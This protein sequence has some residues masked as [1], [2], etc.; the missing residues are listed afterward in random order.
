MARN[1]LLCARFKAVFADSSR[2]PSRENCMSIRLAVSY[3]AAGA[4]AA[5]LVVAASGE[6]QAQA[7]VLR[8]CGAKYQA[9]KAANE[10]GGKSWQDFLK[11]CRASLAEQPKTEAP[12][13][14]P[15]K[16]EAPKVESAKPEPA[17]PE[18]A[19]SEPVKTEP[20]K[21]E[22]PKAEAPAAPAPAAETPKPAAKTTTAQRQ[23]Q[24]AAEWK[25][26][27]AELVKNDPKLKWPKFWSACN[28]R[29]KEGGQ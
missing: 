10:L 2:L 3:A 7:N 8:E 29:L 26:Q 4:F 19:K 14:E 24:C 16:Q 20:A 1:L 27:K 9:A 21:T 22:P 15:A 5:C 17:K 18:P 11:E 6:A 12:A 25:A 28:K 13:A 23:K